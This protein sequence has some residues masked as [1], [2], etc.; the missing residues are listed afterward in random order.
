MT[1][2][3]PDT[4]RGAETFDKQSPLSLETYT[5]LYRGLMPN[6]GKRQVRQTNTP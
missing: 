6:Q 3:P 4:V 2:R 5:S 1:C